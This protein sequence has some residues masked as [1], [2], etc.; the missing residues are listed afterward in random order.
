MRSPSSLI[1]LV[2]LGVWAAY[3]L[4]YWIRRRDHLATART[5]EQLSDAMRVLE[6]RDASPRTEGTDTGRRTWNLHPAAASRPRV[7]QPVTPAAHSEPPR[8]VTAAQ[9]PA[10]AGRVPAPAAPPIPRRVRPGRRLRA[11]L[12]LVALVEL[13]VIGVLVPLGM[14]TVWALAPAG[15]ALVAAFAYVRAGVR[16]ERALRE[17]RRRRRAEEAPRRAAAAPAPA[18]SRPA[19]PARARRS[20]T[21]SQPAAVVESD[22][23][24]TADGL[25]AEPDSV[26]ETA[27]VANDADVAAEATPTP[28][29]AAPEV[30]PE[31]EV[32]YVHLVDEDDIPLTWDPVPVPRPTY[33]MKAR[34]ERPEV[35]PAA[36]TP[37]P[38]PVAL[39]ED[40]AYDERRVAGA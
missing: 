6:A 31:P 37:D 18:A 1:F 24:M 38:E 19:R 3:F 35:P 5:V 4:Q 27:A 26:D 33:T 22:V 11:A 9:A 21:V 32:R 15:V 25:V 36:V 39:P 29:V 23:Q 2:L 34:A 7:S 12:L 28:E 17:A 30:E 10:P 8:W 20:G 14:L 13:A 16:A 40:P